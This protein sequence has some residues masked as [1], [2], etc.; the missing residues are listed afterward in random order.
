[1]NSVY[2]DED[3]IYIDSAIDSDYSYK[4]MDRLKE[5]IDWTQD[6][7]FMFG[8]K[9]KIPRLSSWY[10]DSDANYSYSGLQLT[11]NKWT[12]ELIEIKTIAENQSKQI[13]NSVLLNFY[14]DGNDSMGWHSDDE[15][16]LGVNPV[17][18]SVSL[19]GERRFLIRERK[20]H[21]TK[22]EI[23]LK[24]GSLLIMKS[25]FQSK[26]QHSI[27]KTRKKVG[28]RINLTFRKIV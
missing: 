17:I 1:M 25:G 11:P 12:E 13:Y 16:E 21:K 8:R 15:K 19:G 22:R 4:L 27:P 3:L 7:I 18:A 23:T 5:S 6:E 10:G 26:Y 20:D 28:E 24:N 14:R 9:V 2:E